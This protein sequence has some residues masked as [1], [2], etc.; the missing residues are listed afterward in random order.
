MNA[1]DVAI[2]GTSRLR[3]SDGQSGRY[4]A[5]EVLFAEITIDVLEARLNEAAGAADASRG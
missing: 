1:S 4:S 5:S 3:P 2:P